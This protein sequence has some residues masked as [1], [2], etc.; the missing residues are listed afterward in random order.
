MTIIQI[1]SIINLLLSFD[2]PQATAD[3]VQ[4]ILM[5]SIATSSPAIVQSRPAVPDQPLPTVSPVTSTPMLADLPIRIN[6]ATLNNRLSR[7]FPQGMSATVAV[8]V[9]NIVMQGDVD[10]ANDPAVVFSIDAVAINPASIDT[11]QFTPGHHRFVV[12][13][14]NESQSVDVLI[15]N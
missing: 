11:T 3:N 6:T 4:A 9:S 14:G 1:F 10:I 12:T 2:V 7:L 13:A 15:A 5:A 8:D